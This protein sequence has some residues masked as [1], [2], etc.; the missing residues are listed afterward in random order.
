MFK[1]EM[2]NAEVTEEEID[3]ELKFCGPLGHDFLKG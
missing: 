2:R 1:Q 3:Y